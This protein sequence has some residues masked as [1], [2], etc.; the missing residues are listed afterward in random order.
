[1][2][3][4]KEQQCG[5]QLIELRIEARESENG[6]MHSLVVEIIPNDQ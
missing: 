3:K 2:E 1:M 5:E 4:T 6:L